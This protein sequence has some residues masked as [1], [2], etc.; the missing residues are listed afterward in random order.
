[1]SNIWT[2][3]QEFVKE[4]ESLDIPRVKNPCCTQDYIECMQIAPNGIFR[5]GKDKWSKSYLLI[6]SD[7]TEKTYQ[8]QVV[9]LHNW[10]KVL[11]SFETEMKITAFNRMRNMKFIREEILYQKKYDQFDWLREAY[12]EIIESKILEG[13][14]GIEQIKLVTISLRSNTYEDVKTYLETLEVNYMKLFSTVGSG[15]IPLNANSRLK[16]FYNFF[17][18]GEEDKWNFDIEET[19]AGGRDWKN[20]IAWGYVDFRSR[21]DRFQT[22]K[23]FGCALYV[24]PNSYGTRL[25]DIFYNALCNI[26]YMSMISTDYLPIPVDVTKQTLENK[27]MDVEK[28]IEK[29]QRIR[30]K[31]KNYLSGISRKV[32]KE[33][34]EITKMLDEMDENNQKMLWVGI[35]I[36]LLAD[37]EKQLE[38][39]I[40]TVQ[41]LATTH[42][43]RVQI[44]YHRQREAVNTALPYGVRQVDVM[45]GLFTNS[46][47]ALLPFNTREMQTYKKPFY[48]GI[49]K[50]SKEPIFA[51]RKHL[52]NGNGFVFGI[53]GGG[54][55]LTG[56]KMEA[57]S[58]YLNTD[59][60]I[61][62][63]DPTLEYMD[64]AD[65]FEGTQINLATYTKNY[66]NPMAVDLGSLNISDSDGQIKEK[67]AFVR[68]ICSCA[69]G[70]EFKSAHKSIVSRC[71]KILYE[72]IAEM[73]LE[74]RYQPILSD[75]IEVL[76]EQPE[77]NMIR[78]M[79]L[80]LEIF[81]EGDLNI[82]NHQ[83][84]VDMDN[85]V[86]VFGLRDMSEDMSSLAMMVM[87][88]TIR[89]R[90]LSNFKKGKATWLY[91]D[92]FDWVTKY[93]EQKAYF[94]FL[95]KQVR[96]QGGLCT[97]LTQN[98]SLVL[99]DEDMASFI[100]NSEFTMF[101]KNSDSDISAIKK[102]FRFI[103]DAKL[104]ELNN[105]SPGTGIIRFANCV[106]PFDNVI[107]KT[108]A[109]YDIYNT[110]MHERVAMQKA[111]SANG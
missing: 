97:G 33:K 16:I 108:N 3:E 6:D 17:R 61:I 20:E 30:N 84:N 13:K 25:S 99:K 85:R 83:T 55:S 38:N 100:S 24:E 79:M 56:A 19:I 69:M 34:E 111:R 80:D 23:K 68:A 63:V 53:P 54:K 72:R 109:V 60:D 49:N 48:Y 59:D 42:T 86:L 8:E 47:G 103:S 110:N 71:C 2:A 93:P 10:V 87:L 94:K 101:L 76:K 52:I 45:R 22:D 5:V 27:L 41:Q 106:I 1:M 78:E 75:F 74:E 39:A 81:V 46:A 98:I 104:Q 12:N 65:A 88:E 91:V 15:L 9:F 35:N 96:K 51:N 4:K 21:I 66:L 57:G 7:Y 29:Q 26:S 92:E 105:V 73:P 58:V 95:W 107:D 77:E 31:N 64:V 50:I 11:S 82:F 14:K 89:M 36:V 28:K 44:H 43:C 102:A 18:P 32:Q 70:S 90:I 40:K 62:F 67:T 37:T